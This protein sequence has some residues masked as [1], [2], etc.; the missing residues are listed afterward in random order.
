[1]PL[2]AEGTTAPSLPSSLDQALDLF[3]ASDAAAHW[4]G[5]IHRDAYLRYKRVEADKVASLSPAERCAHY[6]EIY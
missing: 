4:F 6:A 2:P 3:A 5:P 1:L